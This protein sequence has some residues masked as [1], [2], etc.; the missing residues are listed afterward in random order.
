MNTDPEKVYADIFY[1]P[2]HRSLGRI[3][4][5]MAERAAQFSSF[6]ALNGHAQAIDEQAEEH[7]TA[8]EIT[9]ELLRDED[10]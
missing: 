6:E 10:I 8:I 3:P 4:M 7:I 1:L 9:E 2:H 5:P